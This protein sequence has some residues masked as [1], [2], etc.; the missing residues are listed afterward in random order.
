V[1]DL[2]GDLPASQHSIDSVVNGGIPDLS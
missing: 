2:P 1:F